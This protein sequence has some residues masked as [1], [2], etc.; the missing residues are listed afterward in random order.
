MGFFGSPKIDGTELQECLTYLKAATKVIA[1]QGKEADLY[2]DAVVEYGN[3]IMEHPGAG[4]AHDMKKATNRLEQAATE[5]LKRHEEIKNVP[6]AASAMHSAWRE[7]FL[8]NAL[9]A[10]A[11]VKAI[12][13]SPYAL[14]DMAS[15]MTPQIEYAE[16]LAQEHQKRFSRAQ[17]EFRKLLNRLKVSAEVRD[18]IEADAII[19]DDTND[20][21]PKITD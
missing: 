18:T 14:L 9:W 6:V 7:S 12:E 19:T 11:M 15:G 17:D 20:W 4:V 21:E 16:Q 5:I 3:S 13:S 2:N 8:A 10:S 1:F